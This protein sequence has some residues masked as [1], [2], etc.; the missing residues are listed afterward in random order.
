[1]ASMSNLLPNP[2]PKEDADPAVIQ[3]Y[4]S[5]IGSLMYIM[6]GTCPDLTFAI[7]KLSSF[8]SNPSIDHCH[9]ITRVFG[10]LN[11]T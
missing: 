7:Q 8:S 9:A 6:L 2:D 5:A 11:K 10:Y 4:Q 1:M 3:S